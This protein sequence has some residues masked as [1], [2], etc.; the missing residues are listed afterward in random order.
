MKKLLLF[1]S[2]ITGLAACK[3]NSDENTQNRDIQLLSD[4]SAYNNSILSDTTATVM[5]SP[6]I[7]K[8]SAKPVAKQKT[9]VKASKPAP[10]AP[11]VEQTSSV[12]PV[13]T[14]P[15]V[16]NSKDSISTKPDNSTVSA[17]DNKDA[18]S[19]TSGTEVQ[20]KKGWNKATQGAVIGGVTGAVGGAIISKKKGVGA[21]VGGI[22]GAAGGYI[23]GKKMDKKDTA[24]K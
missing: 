9:L 12:P 15:V 6:V 17:G 5:Q 19:A 11:V 24:S 13:A 2:I 22:V 23:I 7:E 18:G 14:P 8:S 16:S 20:K 21:V 10:Q 4:S 1:V 3:S